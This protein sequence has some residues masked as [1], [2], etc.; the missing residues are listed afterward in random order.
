MCDFWREAEAGGGGGGGGE[1]LKGAHDVGYAKR[2]MHILE[3]LLVF[4][5][6]YTH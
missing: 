3:A 2:F 6:I 5:E 4:F 1:R